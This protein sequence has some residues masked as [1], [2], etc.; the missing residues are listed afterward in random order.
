MQIASNLGFLPWIPIISLLVYA[1][2]VS[3]LDWKY[4]D[5][6][7]HKIWL[8]LIALNLPVLIAGYATGL[9]PAILLPV[10]LLFSIM[11]LALFTYYQRGAD[12]W[13]LV[14]ITLFAVINPVYNIIFI[15]T[16]VVYLIVFTASAFWWVLLDNRLM[17]KVWSFEIGR[18]IPFIIPISVAFI[19]AV[20]V[21]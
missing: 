12:G 14:W 1:P 7:T 11:W 20:V 10:T 9:Y 6:G 5:I 8:P 2:V 18:G 3:Y 19:V 16:F 13:W 21:A 15:Q 4:R 17:K